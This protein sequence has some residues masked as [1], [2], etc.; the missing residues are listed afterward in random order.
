[1][2]QT[3]D[4]CINWVKLTKNTVKILEQSKVKREGEALPSNT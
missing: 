1:M 4:A 2:G 3:E